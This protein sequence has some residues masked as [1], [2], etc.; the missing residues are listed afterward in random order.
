M[1]TWHHWVE[2]LAGFTFSIEYHKGQDNAA[3]D[4][5]SKV[6]FKAG[7]RN[8]KVH[9]WTRVNCGNNRK[10]RCSW[11][12]WWLRLMKRY[13]SKSRSL[14]SRLE[15]HH[16]HVWTYM[17]LTGWP[18]QQEDAIH[19]MAIKWISNQKV[20]D[21]KHLLGDDADTVEELKAIL[22]GVEKA[23][24]LPS[25]P[26]PSLPYTGWQGGKNLVVH[27]VPIAH[28]VAAMNGCH[29]RCWTPGSA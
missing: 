14:Q 28:W 12:K 21:L 6:T 3:A 19:K 9:S 20:Q 10:S 29:L 24:A 11:T 18:P 25:N 26:L 17:W 27:V 8:H 7:C 16:M 1:L 4:A 5:L 13:I 23:N 15:L 22:S 2:S